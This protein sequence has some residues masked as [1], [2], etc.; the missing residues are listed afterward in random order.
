MHERN[1]AINGLL[2]VI[3]TQLKN[4][5]DVMIPNERLVFLYNGICTGNL[6]INQL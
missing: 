5:K 2:G 6:G 1:P 4:E 3:N